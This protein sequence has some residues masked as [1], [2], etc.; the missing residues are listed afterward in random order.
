MQTNNKIVNIGEFIKIENSKKNIELLSS[1]KKQINITIDFFVENNNISNYVELSSKI[2]NIKQ[3]GY[4][5][6]IKIKT[7]LSLLEIK[8]KNQTNKY[9]YEKCTNLSLLC[10]LTYFSSY[11]EDFGKVVFDMQI[12][13]NMSLLK[14][15]TFDANKNQ[16]LF[17]DSIYFYDV[18][19]ELK[20]NEVLSEYTIFINQ[21]I[22]T[23]VTIKEI[24]QDVSI[25]DN[26]GW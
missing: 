12:E 4:E 14:I 16:E 1:L 21:L 2:S 5:H 13:K 26:S 11:F 23:L 9:E 24:L 25:S 22:L 18:K 3:K 15:P 6:M 10:N 8:D 7:Y 19:I 20:K 17:N